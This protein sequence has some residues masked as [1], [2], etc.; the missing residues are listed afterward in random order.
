[1][2]R[3]ISKYFIFLLG[4]GK[5][6]TMMGTMEEKGIIPRLCD[7]LFERISR[8]ESEATS[9]KI[10]VSYMEIYNEKVHD[11]LDP[12]GLVFTNYRISVPAN[13]DL[14][15]FQ[16]R[17]WY[18]EKIIRTVQESYAHCWLIGPRSIMVYEQVRLQIQE[19]G[20]QSRPGPTLWILI[21]KYFPRLSRLRLFS[22]F[23][24]FKM[25]CC[26]LQAKVCARTTF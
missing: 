3:V 13:G 23:C 26:Q 1:M 22:S 15:C 10:E 19:S 7:S 25:G 6:Y 2:Q 5:S 20:V 14:H 18:F 21:M 9:F 24:W 12:K 8:L 16:K 17:V 11:L 4:S